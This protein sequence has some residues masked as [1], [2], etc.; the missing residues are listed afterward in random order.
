M[1]FKNTSWRKKRNFL[2][3]LT[4]A[5]CIVTVIYSF[6]FICMGK[7]HSYDEDFIIDQAIYG[8][9][10]ISLE[11]EDDEFSLTIAFKEIFN[12]VKLQLHFVI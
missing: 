1:R 8:S 12:D 4:A 7:S 11:A 6:A 10:N 2:K 5:V 3:I 9:E